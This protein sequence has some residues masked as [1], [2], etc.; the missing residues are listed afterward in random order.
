MLA[1]S[2]ARGS[3]LLQQC[4]P[5]LLVWLLLTSL[6]LTLLR[7]LLRMLTRMLLPL[8]LQRHRT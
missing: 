8:P 4:G 3:N 2:A 6:L 7:M 5:V 1:A